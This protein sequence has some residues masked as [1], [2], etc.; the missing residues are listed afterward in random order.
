MTRI[1]S[2][3]VL[4]LVWVPSQATT[5]CVI[6]QYHHFSDQTPAITSVSPAQ[7]DDHLAYLSTH[8]FNVLPLRQVV[9]ALRQNKTLPDRC[10]SLTVDDAYQSVYTNAFPRLQ[11]LGWP[12]TVF[13]NSEA[14]DRGLA[15]YMTW[16]QMRELSSQGVVFEN[17]GH[18]HIHMIR[19]NSAESDQDWRQ[20][21]T[22]DVNTAQRRIS[23]EIGDAPQLFA[24]PYGEF[25][26]ATAE[27]IDAMGLVGFGQQSGPAWSG[28]DFAA[29]PRFPMA[30]KYAELKN[31]RI[32][33]NTLPLP[34]V[35]L[36]PK[37]PLL[38]L[39]QRRPTLKLKLVAGAYSKAELQCY[40]NGS[41]DVAINWSR[42]I[43]D[44]LTVTP[45]FD[46]RPGRHRTNCTM[47]SPEKGRFHWYSHNWFVRNPD[48]SWYS[49]Y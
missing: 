28:A 24:Y 7:F 11:K 31:F 4:L 38:V 39:Q 32:K 1:L 47:P 42:D 27:I 37:D 23:E 36:W 33:V 2:F 41:S 22:N 8:K 19:K 35:G 30:A 26:P 14:V 16:D 6:L 46:L 21:I 34:V 48:G 45:N 12:L 20:R 40:I 13:V 10:V 15:S 9:A 18:G 25:S 44:Q 43:P 17:H 49:E 29:L 5:H 3:L